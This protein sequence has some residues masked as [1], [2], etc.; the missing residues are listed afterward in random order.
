MMVLVLIFGVVLASAQAVHNCMP[1]AELAV[2]L[3]K[4]SL[5][6]KRRRA[7]AF[8]TAYG[9]RNR[10]PPKQLCRIFLFF[11]SKLLNMQLGGIQTV[12]NLRDKLRMYSSPRSEEEASHETARYTP[13][14][15]K[16]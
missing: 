5:A 16:I 3:S 12:A 7:A 2:V 1:C 15:I 6:A 14:Q 9:G 8:C 11:L 4:A 10:H 13:V